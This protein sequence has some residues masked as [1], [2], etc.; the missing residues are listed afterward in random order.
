MKKRKKFVEDH[1][2]DLGEDLSGLGKDLA[3]LSADVTEDILETDSDEE[4]D[5]FTEDNKKY[6]RNS[7]NLGK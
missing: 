6:I 5:V 1:H 2:D 7:L 4:Y 3:Y